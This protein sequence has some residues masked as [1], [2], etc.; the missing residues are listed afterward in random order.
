MG[1]GVGV[2]TE[3]ELEQPVAAVSRGPLFLLGLG[4][5]CEHCPVRKEM[6]V[7]CQIDRYAFLSSSKSLIKY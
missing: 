3:L 1:V 6:H 2:G 5:G 7:L 4:L